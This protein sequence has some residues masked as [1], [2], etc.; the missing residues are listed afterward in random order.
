METAKNRNRVHRGEPG[1]HEVIQIVNGEPAIENPPVA[2]ASPSSSSLP[3]LTD[4]QTE[5]KALILLPRDG[6]AHY[7]YDLIRAI[8]A[9]IF[10]QKQLKRGKVIDQC[11]VAYNSGIFLQDIH[12]KL[13]NVKRSTFYEWLKAFKEGGIEN[14]APQKGRR[15]E[16]KITDDEK[17]CLLTILRHQNRIKIGSAIRLMKYVFAL[18][19]ISSP[20]SGRTLRR[21]IDQFQKEHN[22]YWTLCREGEKAL[23]DKVLPYVQRDRN[24]LQVG[25]GLVADGHR[26]NFDVINPFTG[27][28]CR[29]VMVLFLD[30]RSSYPLGWEIM[31]EET[32]QCIGSAL[33]NAILTLGKIPK[34]L[35]IDNG[36]AFKAN[37]FNSSVDFGEAGIYGMFLRL[38]I[39]T[40]F[41][42]PYNAQAKITERWWRIFTDWFERLM[43][44]FRGS[45]IEDKPAYLKRNEKLALSAHDPWIPTIQEVNDQLH[46][47]R[48]FYIDQPSRGLD[49]KTPREIFEPDKGPGIN[50]ADLTYLMMPREIKNI[51]R[52]GIDLFGCYWYDEALYGLKDHVLI[53]YSLS[54]LSQI[55]C[56][57]KNEFLCILKPRAKAH[58]MASESGTPKDMEDVKRMIAQKRSLKS[59]TVKL[60]K[61]L[62]KKQ[63]QL[64][65][66]EIIQ[67]VPDVVETIEKIEAEKPKSKFISP[68][69]DEPAD[70]EPY[71]STSEEGKTD[72]AADHGSHL[73]CPRL[74]E[75]YDMYNW[76]YM[77]DIKK[78]NITDLGW[79]DWYEDGYMGKCLKDESWQANLRYQLSDRSVKLECDADG[80]NGQDERKDYRLG[81]D[82]LVERRW[83]EVKNSIIVDPASGLSRP[84]EEIAPDDERTWY[85]FYRGIERRFPGTLTDGDWKEVKKHEGSR[86]WELVYHEYECFRLNRAEGG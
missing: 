31:L 72:M 6:I 51:T 50:A 85:G 64:P 2:L 62:G 43:P 9:V 82:P 1:C 5:S 11:L 24:L 34:W 36:K 56:F 74:G 14:L 70:N 32:V 75:G 63:E 28:P 52:N 27:K 12:K 38:G 76:Y 8:E 73:S 42:Q 21:Y 79:I 23:N 35:L 67:E 47:L 65:W 77:N 44:S 18:K 7:R 84:D 22:D 66:K 81:C 39:H 83:R 80:E 59:Q 49:G 29:A 68:F 41:S 13:G 30:W 45:S 3:A 17:N 71:A 55:Y 61:L 26:L 54:D 53:K 48:E 58:P 37:I 40:H 86:E 25:E 10:S 33:R 15:G 60:Y 4:Q 16:S 69:V 78:Y 57:Y 46:E 20:S 19:E